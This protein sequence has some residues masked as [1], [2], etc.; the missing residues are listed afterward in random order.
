MYYIRLI[1]T[2][3]VAHEHRLKHYNRSLPHQK[4]KYLCLVAKKKTYWVLNGKI[5]LGIYYVKRKYLKG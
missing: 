4:V 2:K 3:N 5:V 1:K